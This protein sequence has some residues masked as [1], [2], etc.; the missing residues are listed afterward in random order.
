MANLNTS[1]VKVKLLKNIYTQRRRKNL[2]TS[3]VKVKRNK[4]IKALSLFL[5]KY[6]LC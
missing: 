1:Y 3:Y 4:T 5:F 6:I 2:N